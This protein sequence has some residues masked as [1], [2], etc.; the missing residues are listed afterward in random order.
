VSHFS[1]VGIELRFLLK[2]FQIGNRSH[3]ETRCKM[4]HGHG[5][6][7]QND[8]CHKKSLT[9]AWNIL[10]L[11]VFKQKHRK[12]MQRMFLILQFNNTLHYL[13]I[14]TCFYFII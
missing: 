12:I 4:E 6:D 5:M 8:L 14:V 2:L 1:K 10:F 13:I 9:I 3:E 11:Y 7:V